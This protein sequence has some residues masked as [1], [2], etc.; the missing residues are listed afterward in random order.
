MPLISIASIRHVLRGGDDS[1]PVSRDLIRRI[2]S[3]PPSGNKPV[4]F[5]LAKFTARQ[6]L[7][8]RTKAS[9]KQKFLAVPYTTIKSHSIKFNRLNKRFHRRKCLVPCLCYKFDFLE[10]SF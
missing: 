6:I 1:S 10:R 4:E 8:V 3:F 2:R 5:V 7:N 9:E